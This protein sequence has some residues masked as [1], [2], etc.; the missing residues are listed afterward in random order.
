MVYLIIF[1]FF[2][3]SIIILGFKSSKV[4]SGIFILL[5]IIFILIATFRSPEMP[6][7]EN[8]YN[9]FVFG[10]FERAEIGFI[11]YVENIKHISN[12]PIFIFGAVATLSVGIKLFVIRKLS[13][14]FWG[15]I[16]VYLSN[17]F[18][19]HDIIQ[20]RVAVASGILLWSTKYLEERNLK[21]FLLS[22]ALASLFHISSIVF[23]PM[24]LI[25]TTKPQK[26]IY[27]LIIPISYVLALSGI[28]FGNIAS[29]INLEQVQNL[30][31]MHQSAMEQDI[32]VNINLFNAV[33]LIRTIICFYI[34]SNINKIEKYNKLSIVLTKIYAISLVAFNLLSDIPVIAFRVSEL[35]QVVEILLIPTILLIPHYMRINKFVLICYAG[36]ILF[37]NIFYNE[38]LL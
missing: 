25:N 36:C 16:L 1:I 32:G 5:N 24:W 38:F 15:S 30:W 8:Y 26:N 37:I 14:F 19:L 23:L 21:K 20:I 22:V 31:K 4:S 29:L 13:P 34:I 2:V 35:L 6:D 7:Y 10:G 18:I 9:Y 11:T 12:N 3:L 17:I 28:T 27:I 33:H